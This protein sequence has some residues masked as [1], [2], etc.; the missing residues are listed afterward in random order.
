MRRRL[1]SAGILI[2]LA[3]AAWQPL[4]AGD[5]EAREFANYM[6][7]KLGMPFAK[8]PA[9]NVKEAEAAR[10]KLV[11]AKYRGTFAEFQKDWDLQMELELGP[12][13]RATVIGDWTEFETTRL[14]YY[15]V[16]ATMT[17]VA[18]D[19]RRGMVVI[20]Y[21]ERQGSR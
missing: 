4:A 15:R 7:R 19:T 21:A 9:S 13:A 16:G 3:V 8:C 6:I 20:M 5:R 12:A 2:A 17:G 11:C 18:F 1:V 14:R 10:M